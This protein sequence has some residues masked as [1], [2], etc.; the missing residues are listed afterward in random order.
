M[1]C[2]LLNYDPNSSKLAK[3]VSEVENPRV[4]NLNY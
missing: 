4:V 3:L 2:F 1:H